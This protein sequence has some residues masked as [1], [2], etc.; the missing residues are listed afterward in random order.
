[1]GVPVHPTHD[2]SRSPTISVSGITVVGSF[3]VPQTVNFINEKERNW[4]EVIYVMSNY[5][6]KKKTTDTINYLSSGKKIMSLLMF[7][8]C[9]RQTDPTHHAV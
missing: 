2:T 3:D 6:N 7:K 5:T 9:P 8:F 4:T 1:M